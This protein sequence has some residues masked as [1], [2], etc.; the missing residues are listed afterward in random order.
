MTHKNVGAS[1]SC[2]HE[3]GGI[4]SPLNHLG[5]KKLRRKKQGYTRYQHNVF[6]EFHFLHNYYTLL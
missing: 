3:M 2:M 1:E 5:F 4:V 6:H